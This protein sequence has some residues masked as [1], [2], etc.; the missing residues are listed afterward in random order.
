[1]AEATP[2]HNSAFPTDVNGDGNTSAIDVLQ[3]LNY[4]NHPGE[5]LANADS[6]GMVDTNGD[7][8]VSAIDALFIVNSMNSGTAM[9][10]V[11]GSLSGAANELP[12]SR[13]GQFDSE[14]V[15]Y[16]N[17]SESANDDSSVDDEVMPIDNDDDCAVHFG[18]LNLS[19]Y[20]PLVGLVQ[21]SSQRLLSRFDSDSNAQL[22]EAEVPARVWQRL[23]DLSVDADADG[24]LTTLELEAQATAA[25]EKYFADRD[26][27]GDGLL[28]EAEVGAIAWS[29]LSTADSDDTAGVSIDELATWI[30]A[31]QAELPELGRHHE[32]LE[33]VDRI[34]RRAAAGI[35]RF[36]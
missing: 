6:A 17:E 35:R 12:S 32:H 28:V 29:R 2:L 21:S 20:F 14:S 24:V 4:L 1:M 36:L 11:P 22:V 8:S 34:F 18:K 25:R 23:V 26:T 5:Y 27:N 30:V 13:L 31:R 15:D 9:L 7:G 19:Q 33:V 16:S 3:I 10:A